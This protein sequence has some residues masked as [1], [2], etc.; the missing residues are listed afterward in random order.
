MMPTAALYPMGGLVSTAMPT[1]IVRAGNHHGERDAFGEGRLGSVYIDNRSSALLVVLKPDVDPGL[2]RR[3]ASP[4][5]ERLK[6]RRSARVDARD[7]IA[8]VGLQRRNG[9]GGS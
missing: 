3:A 4:R 9:Q 5:G 8:S 7:V 6:V 1:W 2:S